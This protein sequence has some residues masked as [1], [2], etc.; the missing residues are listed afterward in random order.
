[1]RRLESS[2]LPGGEGRIDLIDAFPGCGLRTED[3]CE[4][5]SSG[6]VV[7]GLL[8]GASESD[9]EKGRDDVSIAAKR[10]ARG[11][12]DNRIVSGIGHVFVHDGVRVCWWM[13]S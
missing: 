6:A 12:R 13:A 8:A 2:C 5:N 4:C 3:S 10:A 7:T 11:D 9:L 1:M